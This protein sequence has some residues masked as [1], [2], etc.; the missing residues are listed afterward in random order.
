MYERLLAVA[1]NNESADHSAGLP[2]NFYTDSGHFELEKRQIFY[3]SWICIGHE[4]M[5]REPGNYFI[6]RVVDHEVFV[7]RNAEGQLNAFFNACRHR[8]HPLV[9]KDGACSR[10]ITCPYHAWSY[11]YDGHL[12]NAPYSERVSTFESKA[13]SL[14]RVRVD[15]LAGAV[16]VNL[17]SDAPPL[18][19]VFPG[20]EDEILSFKPNVVEQE[21][22]FDNPFPHHCNWKAS[23]ENYSECYHCGPVHGYLTGTIIDPESYK[24]SAQGLVQKHIVASRQDDSV[25]RLWHLWPNTGMGLYPIPNVGLVWCIRHMYPVTCSESIYHYRWFADVGGPANAIREYA[26]HHAETTGVEDAAVSGGVQ[27]GMESLGFERAQLLLTPEHGVSS[28][29]VIKYFH[30]LVRTAVSTDAIQAD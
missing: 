21:L 27:R 30:D 19:D 6:G 22:I 3:K 23:V 14:N 12:I 18:A 17:D 11:S 28:E 2:A 4:C 10:R 29:H 16:F 25:Q 24:L 13:I 5:A 20:V 7:I 1:C 15:T 8:G 9:S 26:K